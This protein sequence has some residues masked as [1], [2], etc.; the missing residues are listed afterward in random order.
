MRIVSL[1]LN[2]IRSAVKK[3]VLPWVEQ[4][5]PDIVCVQE[6]RIQDHQLTAD[7]RAPGG[8]HAHCHTR[9]HAVRLVHRHLLAQHGAILRD[10]RVARDHGG[11]LVARHQRGGVLG[12][13]H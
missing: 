13:L 10:E 8:L 5:A 12:R 7:M 1:N 9:R 2:G 4:H 11:E 6:T 3:G